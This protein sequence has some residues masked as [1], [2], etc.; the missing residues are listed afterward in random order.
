[1]RS[2]VNFESTTPR[3]QIIFQLYKYRTSTS[4]RAVLIQWLWEWHENWFGL[5]VKEEKNFSL[6][7][8]SH[9]GILLM[10]LDLKYDFD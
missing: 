3:F 6:I 7:V 4:E 8:D 10:N 9:P 2:A 5:S 1:M